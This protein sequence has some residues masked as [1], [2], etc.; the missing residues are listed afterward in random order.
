MFGLA[1]RLHKT[2]S[3]IQNLSREELIGWEAY[4]KITNEGRR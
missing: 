4:F 2:L 3:E 1:D